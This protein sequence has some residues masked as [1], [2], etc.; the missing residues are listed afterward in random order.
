MDNENS[1][2]ESKTIGKS[3][4]QNSKLFHT[5]S[6]KITPEDGWIEDKTITGP[7]NKDGLG[8]GKKTSNYFFKGYSK[9]FKGV[10]NDPKIT[11]PFVNIA[12][13][14]L[15]I[16]CAIAFLGEILPFISYSIGFSRE[17]A[18]PVA[19]LIFA[20]FWGSWVLVLFWG[21]WRANKDIDK[22]QKQI[23]KENEGN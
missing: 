6:Y 19:K 16:V 20:A 7:A 23:D 8:Q 5:S 3:D 22:V 21:K 15:I 11:R 17:V 1:K 9:G 13:W 2:K 18:H 4:E 14:I 12:F 10:T